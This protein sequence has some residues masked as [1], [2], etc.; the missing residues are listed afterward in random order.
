[1]QISIAT[2]TK[3]NPQKYYRV[4][5]YYESYGTIDRALTLKDARK[6]AKQHIDDTDGECDIAIIQY[7]YDTKTYKRT[8][9][10][11]YA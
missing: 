4:V 9:E 3:L 10:Y 8:K 7:T 2:I 1:M 11:N 6:I 5:D